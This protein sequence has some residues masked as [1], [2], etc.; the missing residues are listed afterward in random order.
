MIG[1][2]TRRLSS[3]PRFRGSSSYRFVTETDL[4]LTTQP[5]SSTLR[6]HAAIESSLELVKTT[7][8]PVWLVVP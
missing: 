8:L 2:L 1:E 3:T 4:P 6:F 7:V 5:Q